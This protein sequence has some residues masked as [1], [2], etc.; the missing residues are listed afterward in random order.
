MNSSI[1]KMRLFFSLGLIFSLFFC[2]SGSNQ[3]VP[4]FEK[5][6]AQKKAMQGPK[7]TQGI[8]AVEPLGAVSLA[9]DFASMAGKQLRARKLIIAPGGIVAVHQHDHRPGMAFILSGEIYEYRNGAK[10]VLK[11]KGT[12][13]FEQT[14]VIHYWVNK[15][16]NNVEAIVVDIVPEKN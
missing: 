6:I 10:P 2:K 9:K 11:K 3:V 7:K 8:K 15:S 5:K 14:G 16:K 12:V 4:E 13:A 1:S